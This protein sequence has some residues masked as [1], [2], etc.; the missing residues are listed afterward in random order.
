MRKLV[1]IIVTIKTLSCAMAVSKVK[2]L[3]ANGY[4]SDVHI[5]TITCIYTEKMYNELRVYK[6]HKLV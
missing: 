6:A 3:G 5:H 1:T 4:G 2:T